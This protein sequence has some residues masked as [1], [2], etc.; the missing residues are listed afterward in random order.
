MILGAVLE[1]ELVLSVILGKPLF[2]ISL[3]IRSLMLRVVF[4][5]SNSLFS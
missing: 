5:I 4:W 1:L 3:M 2:T